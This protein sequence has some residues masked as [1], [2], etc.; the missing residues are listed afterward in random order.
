M[1]DGILLRDR[2]LLN[3]EEES[4]IL[5]VQTA[6]RASLQGWTRAKLRI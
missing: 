5:L 2:L 1:L 6:F 4:R 3:Y